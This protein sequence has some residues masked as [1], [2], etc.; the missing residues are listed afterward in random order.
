M[1]ICERAN[2]SELKCERN[3]DDRCHLL[4]E[5]KF[6]R[7]EAHADLGVAFLVFVIKLENHSNLCQGAP[8]GLFDIIVISPVGSV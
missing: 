2:E 7:S 8:Q 3:A 6:A 1:R 5:A 4:A